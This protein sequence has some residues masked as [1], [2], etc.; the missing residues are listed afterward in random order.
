MPQLNSESEG[1]S[2][3]HF[4]DEH[5]TLLILWGLGTLEPLPFLAPCLRHLFIDVEQEYTHS[6]IEE[7]WQL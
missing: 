4:N 1:K 2:P 6:L 5:D 3:Q 7:S